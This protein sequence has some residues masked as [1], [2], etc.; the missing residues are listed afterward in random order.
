MQKYQAQ[1][2]SLSKM[3]SEN[4]KEKKLPSS[5]YDYASFALGQMAELRCPTSKI[6]YQFSGMTNEQ[7]DEF[8]VGNQ[9]KRRALALKLLT[10][11]QKDRQV[12]AHQDMYR[13]YD[14]LGRNN[15]AREQTEILSKLLGTTDPN[16]LHRQM[17]GC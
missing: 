14:A 15:E 8:V 13:W 11:P 7:L 16:V 6:K 2:D 5:A 1:E 4:E 10:Q 17:I 12:R 9:V 3:L